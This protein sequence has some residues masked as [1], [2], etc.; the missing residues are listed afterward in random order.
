N[1]WSLHGTPA[2]ISWI[3]HW[4]SANDQH[5]GRSSLSV[6]L[7]GISIRGY[8]P[9]M[10]R[11]AQGYVAKHGTPSIRPSTATLELCV[12][13]QLMSSQWIGDLCSLLSRH[14]SRRRPKYGAI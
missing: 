10:V 2:A 11:A 4:L 7:R 12:T 1:P 14:T 9:A 8:S 6:S 5:Q 13:T 3:I